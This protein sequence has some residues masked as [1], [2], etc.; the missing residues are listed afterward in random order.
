MRRR[1]RRELL[2]LRYLALTSTG[3]VIVLAGMGVAQSQ[4][5]RQKFEEIDVERI[6]IVARDGGVRMVISNS[7]RQAPG[8]IDGVTLTRNQAR[9]PGM[10]F[11]NEEGDE[12][13]GLIFRGSSRNGVVGAGGSLTFDQFKQDQTVALQYVDEGGRRR[14]GLAI[15]DRPQT[16]LARYLPLI[17]KRSASRSDAERAAVDREIAKLGPSASRMFAGRDIDGRAMVSLSDA[18]GRRRL[19]LSVDPEGA[20][21]I[22]FLDAAG[23]VVREVTP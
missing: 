5:A 16:S 14:A 8:V 6:N 21:R 4:S 17:E 10:I 9:P 12:V 20:P 13:G 3:G 19:V 7:E 22:Q 15:I 11:F 23:K 2:M 1:L 18:Q